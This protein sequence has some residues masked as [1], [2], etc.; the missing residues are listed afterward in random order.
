VAEY[1]EEFSGNV[2][3]TEH[4]AVGYFIPLFVVTGTEN[5]QLIQLLI[6]RE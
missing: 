5:I 4:T 6:L 1:R 3:Q 2:G